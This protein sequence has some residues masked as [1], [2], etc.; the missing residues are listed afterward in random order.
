MTNLRSKIDDGTLTNEDI[1]KNFLGWELKCPNRSYDPCYYVHNVT[2][3][4][5]TVGNVDRDWL[6]NASL[7][8]EVAYTVLEDEVESINLNYL[9]AIEE[10]YAELNTYHTNGKAG[11]YI[12]HSA[13]NKDLC[14]AIFDAIYQAK[15]TTQ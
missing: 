5:T 7:M 13:D 6:G 14:L 9:P 4:I 1:R 11:E 10:W 2:E 15:E 3:E 12:H 8:L